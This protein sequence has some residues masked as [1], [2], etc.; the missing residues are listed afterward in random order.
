VID[1][2]AEGKLKLQSVLSQMSRWSSSA[3]IFI[4][5]GLLF[6]ASVVFEPSSVGQSSLA[7]LWSF[8]AILMIV[9]LGQ[10]LVIQQ[11]G[12]DLSV[13]GF[14]SLTCVLV[15]RIPNGNSGKLFEAIL[16][17]L[18]VNVLA[19]V[20]NGLMITRIGMM[21]IVQTLGMNAV[22]YGIDIAISSGTPTQTTTALQNFTNR[23]VLGVPLP[24]AAAIVVALVLEFMMK[25]TVGGRRFEAGGASERAGRAA[26]LQ[27]DRY[28]FVAYVTSAILYTIAGI[29]LSGIVSQ[30][31]AF[32]GDQYLLASVAA[33]VLGGTALLGGVGSP[34]ASAVG[35]IFLVQL[36][37]FTLATGA[38]AAWQNIVQAVAL[39]VG[40]GVYG[41]KSRIGWSQ[42][43]KRVTGSGARGSSPGSG[44]SVPEVAQ[45]VGGT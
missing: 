11:R 45:T 39:A 31:D 44:D 13:P 6:V 19:G 24:F 2:K 5:T 35:A 29:L 10:T 43:L 27:V 26:G 42:L 1:N 28:Q 41:L 12:I 4:A 40:V 32:Q 14:I 30:P 23:N 22:L 18:G 34:I 36:E 33:V 7:A 25:R 17:A 15:T 20:V 38:S 37:Q 8:A 21:P 16:I 9:S 3:A